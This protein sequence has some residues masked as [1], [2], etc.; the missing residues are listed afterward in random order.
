MIRLRPSGPQPLLLLIV[1][2]WAGCATKPTPAN[3][4]HYEPVAFQEYHD[5]SRVWLQ[6][7]RQLEVRYGQVSFAEVEAW[8]PGRKLS[9]AYRSETG[10]V[11]LDL[12]TGR[13]LTVVSGWQQH[14]LD[15]YLEQAGQSDQS[16]AGL[17]L[18]GE[19]AAALWKLEL[20]RAYRDRLR[21]L[22]PAQAKLLAQAQAQW[23]QFK[24]A[25]VKFG[26]S[27][28]AEDAGTIGSV[29]AVERVAD[30]YRQRALSLAEE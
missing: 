5:P 29:T 12:Q 11:L 4:L 25:E 23:E 9:F 2:W 28:N 13:T 15:T 3:W 16:T 21:R 26:H 17:V 27:L 6:D 24:A 30:L 7:Q 10:A 22:K 19:L 20:Q 18:N 8:Q 1:W 14:P